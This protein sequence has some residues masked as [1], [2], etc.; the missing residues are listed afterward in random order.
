VLDSVDSFG[1]T[2]E[3]FNRINSWKGN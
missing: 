2:L 1:V 3:K